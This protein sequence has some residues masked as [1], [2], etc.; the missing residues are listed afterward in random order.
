MKETTEVKERKETV[1]ERCPPGD[2]WIQ[3]NTE[4][5]VF[6]SLTEALEYWYQKTGDTEFFLSAREGIVQVVKSEEVEVKPE[7][8][9]YSLYGE[10]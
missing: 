5:P 8:K 10:E 9:S 4:N 1:L 7:I 6:D 3:V 2:R